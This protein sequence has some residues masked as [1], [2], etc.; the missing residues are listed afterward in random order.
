MESISVAYE[1]I[2]PTVLPKERCDE[3]LRQVINDDR[4]VQFF[5]SAYCLDMK[6]DRHRPRKFRIIDENLSRLMH[7]WQ[8]ILHQGPRYFLKLAANEDNLGKIVTVTVLACQRQ[9]CSNT[10]D[11]NTS[12]AL[13][14]RMLKYVV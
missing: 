2:D 3:A 8:L 12:F 10:G 11:P 14:T 5:I 1:L 6:Q 4:T 7:V 13:S 9:N